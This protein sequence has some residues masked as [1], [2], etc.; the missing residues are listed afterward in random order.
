VKRYVDLNSN[1]FEVRHGASLLEV[2]ARPPTVVVLDVDPDAHF[3]GRS[4][5]A[6]DGATV[7]ALVADLLEALR[8]KPSGAPETLVEELADV[9]CR[10]RLGLPLSKITNDRAV[11]SVRKDA[12]AVLS[13]LAQQGAEWLPSEQAACNAF[14]WGHNTAPVSPDIG[15]EDRVRDGVV[16]ILVLVS[17]A[18]A[19]VLAAKDAERHDLA[20][21]HQATLTRLGLAEARLAAVLSITGVDLERVIGPEVGDVREIE[22]AGAKVISLIRDRAGLAGPGPDQDIAA[23]V[24][25]HAAGPIPPAPDELEHEPYCDGYACAA[26]NAE[27]PK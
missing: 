10:D 2:G 25:E 5:V 6:L 8:E 20:N 22:D 13:H 23:T 27:E 1:P 21:A 17:A 14:T 26:C 7:R 4:G 16:A 24:A 18:L 12:R 19:P 9:L 15:D 11:E 3:D